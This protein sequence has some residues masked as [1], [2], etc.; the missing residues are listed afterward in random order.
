MLEITG[1]N[2]SILLSIGIFLLTIASHSQT[3]SLTWGK[4]F[5]GVDGSNYSRTVR[6]AI[7]GAGNIYNIGIYRGTV[8]FN[9]GTAVSSV[10]AAGEFDVFVQKLDNDGN[11]LW[12]KTFGSANEERPIDIAVDN[13]GGVYFTMKFQ[14]SIDV[15]PNA[16]TQTITASGIDTDTRDL[17]VVKLN[18]NGDY[19]N[20]SQI[21]NC[22]YNF[23]NAE[24]EINN[25]GEL[26]L[27]YNSEVQIV[28]IQHLNLGN[29]SVISEKEIA[30]NSGSGQALINN[31]SFDNSDNMLLAGVFS[32][33]LS[34]NPDQPGTTI[35]SVSNTFDSFV[36]KLTSSET[37]VFGQSFG[38][39]SNFDEAISITSDDAG[40]VF[41]LGRFE[42]APDFNAG[43]GTATLTSLGSTDVFV[44]KLSPT[45]AFVWVKQFGS[46]LGED[47]GTIRCDAQGNVVSTFYVS[48]DFDANPNA[49][50]NN[51]ALSMISSVIVVLDN[52]GDFVFADDISWADGTNQEVHILIDDANSIY[53]AGSFS[54]ASFDSDPSSNVV[55]IGSSTNR[56]SYN[57]KWSQCAAVT[58]TLSIS[59]NTTEVCETTMVSFTTSFTNGG[60]SP[61]FTWNVNGNVVATGV[62]SYNTNMLVA[63]DLVTC[64][65]QSNAECASPASITSN[66]VA[67]TCSSV[68]G[69]DELFFSEYVEGSGNNKAFEI[70]NPTSSVVD[71]SAYSVA[72][73]TNGGTTANST[74]NL[75]GTLN[76]QD[77]IVVANNQGVA[78]LL[79][80]ADVTTGSV[81]SFNGDD[82][83]VLIHNGENID[84]IGEIGVD[85]GTNWPVNDGGFTSEYTLVRKPDVTGPTTDWSVGQTQWNS[86]AQNTFTNLGSHTVAVSV[87]Y[88]VVITANDESI[89]DGDFV[90]FIASVNPSTG[91]VFTYTWYIDGQVSQVAES[92]MFITSSLNDGSI[93]YC[94]ATDEQGT[95][96]DQSN[97]LVIDVQSYPIVAVTVTQNMLT[98][99]PAGL[100]YQWI[101]CLTG[102]DIQGATNVSFSPA[103]SGNYAVEVSANGCSATSECEDIIIVSVEP[104]DRSVVN[105][106][107]N[108]FSNSIVLECD[109]NEIDQVALIDVCG[110]LIL[111]ENVT[112]QRVEILT[113]QLERGIYFLKYGNSIIPLVKE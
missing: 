59:A 58:P 29:L 12:V 90:T 77:V 80:I 102:Q 106:Y 43:A 105:V 50:T 94:T 112:S 76:P 22:T 95:V 6:H 103:Q 68:G 99:Q 97:E 75:T 16:G 84:I 110:K 17:V 86:F 61:I 30:N 5:G 108:P 14:G 48:D 67:M 25:A 26:F 11:F 83:L 10:T 69:G 62:S 100:N 82:A 2:K 87:D 107:P 66:A 28:L 46:A 88:E 23:I 24:L 63:G 81:C 39:T 21:T 19:Q 35:S 49:G 89:C 8:D 54:G 101:D 9:S 96:V 42:N 113:P 15:N 70:Y 32:Q 20:H 4:A 72:L 98:A 60:T 93:V 33:S 13:N 55:N 91:E 52:N 79:A 7:D 51:I 34:M 71:L 92:F 47:A 111:R 3:P 73:F 1:M 44:Q 31:V 45:G 56:S 74:L 78:E 38:T 36:I 53:L 104:N 41:V 37:F 85:P 109:P 40:N 57:L 65:M 27:V 18:S 64:T